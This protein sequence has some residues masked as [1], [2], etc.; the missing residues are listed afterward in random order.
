[1]IIKKL[2][3]ALIVAS[4]SLG[5]TAQAEVTDPLNVV[6]V[7]KCTG[8]DSHLG[9][10]TGDL[11]FSLDAKASH[12][13]SSFGTYKIDFKVDVAGAKA[14]YTGYAAAQGQ[15]LAVYFANDDEKEP[16]DR[17]VGVAV[18][19]H[20]QDANGKYTTTLHKTYYVPDYM[21]D[22][23]EGH[24]SGGRGVEVCTKQT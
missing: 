24:G 22:S 16:T 20:D 7:Y 2:S 11:T 3:F 17:G 5:G 10:F 1:M 18:I 23:K 8:Y 9:P 21:R 6:G 15:S 14:S 19:T 13:P 12:F 4:L